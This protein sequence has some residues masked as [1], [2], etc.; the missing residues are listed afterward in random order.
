M[1]GDESGRTQIEIDKRVA[2]LEDFL[3]RSGR[4]NA[5]AAGHTTPKTKTKR[6]AAKPPAGGYD[7][8]YDDEEDPLHWLSSA[9]D[10][11]LTPIV[12]CMSQLSAVSSGS[13]SSGSTSSGFMS[14][15]AA[16]SDCA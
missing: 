10:A 4:R 15:P 1:L 8:C 11:L 6:A 5:R 13:V 7:Y 14:L 3:E 16:P 2:I 9:E 12:P